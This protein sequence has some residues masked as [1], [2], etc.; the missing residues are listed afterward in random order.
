MK[1]PARNRL[2]I[3]AKSLDLDFE[4]EAEYVTRAYEAVRT[5]LMERFQDSLELNVDDILATGQYPVAPSKSREH[6]NIVVCNDVY[7]KIYL[8][9]RDEISDTAFAKFIDMNQ[10]NRVYI[11]RAQQDSF[12]K[13]FD[14]GKVLWRELTAAGKAAV[15][16]DR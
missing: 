1:Q 14:F 4:G 8:L 9:S 11:N 13:Y 12:E 3:H 7:N 16:K 15:S 6:V 2:K 10:I 5:V